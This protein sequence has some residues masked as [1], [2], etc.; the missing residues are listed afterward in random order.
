MHTRYILYIF[1]SS[2][3]QLRVYDVFC[4]C[5]CFLFFFSI[6]Y[7]YLIFIYYFCCYYCC[8]CSLSL[9]NIPFSFQFIYFSLISISLK[10]RHSTQRK[11]KK[12][13][14]H[15]PNTLTYGLCLHIKCWFVYFTSI[16]YVISLSWFLFF[17]VVFCLLYFVQ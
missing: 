6:Q 15:N 9:E 8:C 1:Y 3:S 2:L 10:H 11:R 12:N 14:K 5:C 16:V 7:F 17:V 4:C 13:V